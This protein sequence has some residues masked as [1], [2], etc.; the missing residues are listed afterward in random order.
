[1]SPHFLLL[2]YII[3]L[4]YT[5]NEVFFSEICNNDNSLQKVENHTNGRR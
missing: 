2:M 5:D 1:M 4:Y 3:V